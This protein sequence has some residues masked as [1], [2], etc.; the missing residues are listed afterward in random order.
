MSTTKAIVAGV[1]LVA[2]L[3]IG[4]HLMNSSRPPLAADPRPT[5]T[6]AATSPNRRYIDPE[7]SANTVQ[8]TTVPKAAIAESPNAFAREFAQLLGEPN[9]NDRRA[10]LRTLLT[11]WGKA[12]PYEALAAVQSMGLSGLEK[13]SHDLDVF[14]GWAASDPE[15]AWIHAP[16]TVYPRADWIDAS[17]TVSARA[18]VGLTKPPENLFL[19][20]I[21]AVMA[22]NGRAAQVLQLFVENPEIATFSTHKSMMDSMVKNDFEGAVALATGIPP[23]GPW[24]ANTVAVIAGN[25]ARE[26]PDLAFDFVR[27]FPDVQAQALSSVFGALGQTD[28]AR[29]AADWIARETSPNLR[30]RALRYYFGIQGEMTDQI[31]AEALKKL[32]A[33]AAK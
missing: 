4:T 15:A 20:K 32:Q 17:R 29:V 13:E 24:R 28:N 3:S 11:A 8:P 25:L 26:F 1:G 27:E 12:A 9:T 14:A 22:E 5:A 31:R 6:V 21:A 23:Y 33:L 16:R 10:R 2:A 7:R 19:Q 30:E 18:L